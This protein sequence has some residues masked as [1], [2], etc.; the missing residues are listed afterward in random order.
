[1]AKA[2]PW[3]QTHALLKCA[4]W[5]IGPL[6]DLQ[7]SL[8]A[9]AF[10]YIHVHVRPLVPPRHWA[11][12][13]SPR[14]AWGIITSNPNPHSS[15]RTEMLACHQARLG[16]PP[17]D[18]E[19]SADSLILPPLPV[20]V[21]DNIFLYLPVK[22]AISF[23]RETVKRKLLPLVACPELWCSG[24]MEALRWLCK[25][26][27]SGC[28][29]VTA[30]HM[31]LDCGDLDVAQWLHDKYPDALR[32]LVTRFVTRTLVTDGDSGYSDDL[33]HALDVAAEQG[34]LAVIQWLHE[35]GPD[36][37]ATP[38]A[39]DLAAAEGDLA[40]VQWLHENRSEGCTVAAMD[41]AAANGHLAVVQWLHENRS[42]GCTT[43]AMNDAARKGLHPVVEWLHGNRKEGCTTRAMDDAASAGH[44]EVVKFLH[45]HR[46]EGCTARA[47]DDAA[48]MGHL[49]IVEYLH[50]HRKE[51]CTTRAMDY[52]ASAGHLE[53]VRFL[54]IHRHEGCTVEALN[55]A[56]R[57][58]RLEM[59]QWLFTHRTEGYTRERLQLDL[60]VTQTS[61]AAIKEWLSKQEYGK[62]PP[63]DSD[64][65]VQR[66]DSSEDSDSDDDFG[67][68][69]D[70]DRLQAVNLRR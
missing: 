9:T 17:D 22:F 65:D 5:T 2:A 40:V 66:N 56:I 24:N 6:S 36:E 62:E 13:P 4:W 31:A 19:P 21:V 18:V 60:V 26:N 68:R 39:M 43:A 48:S 35:R 41:E 53:V 57:S 16:S 58:G 69:N 3:A 42:E 23:K 15:L 44:L 25:Y 45:I 51:G 32:T 63:P 70:L 34:Q 30:L 61:G 29:E 50:T 14:L 49:A 38:N 33:Y 8:G 37:M 54:H 28:D 27:V 1:M 7:A 12:P 47:M 52:A 64:D 20:E 59:V 46:H 55:S 67:R 10:F 11:P